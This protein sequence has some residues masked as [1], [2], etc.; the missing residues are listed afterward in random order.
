[1]RSSLISVP[2]RRLRSVCFIACGV[3][4]SIALLPIPS[5]AGETTVWPTLVVPAARQTVHLAIGPPKEHAGEAKP[6]IQGLAE[7]GSS[8]EV[9]P[10]N[11]VPGS[12]ALGTADCLQ[13]AASIPPRG[14]AEGPRRFKIVF[15]NPSRASASEFRFTQ[16]D[17]KSIGLWDGERPVLVYNYGVVTDESVPKTDARGSRGCY[18]HP[19][20]GLDGEVITD[21]FPK[22]HYHHHGIFWSWPHVEIGGREYDLWVYKN[23]EQRFVRWLGRECGSAAAALG[24]EN[25][26]FVGEKKVMIERVWVRVYKPAGI[27]RLHRPGV[28]LDPGRGADHA[29]RSGRQELWRPESALRPTAREGDPDHRPE[30]TN[31]GGPARHAAGLGRLECKVPGRGE[32]QRRSDFRRSGPSRF[33]AHLAHPPLRYPLRR[34]AGRACEDLPAGRAHPLELPNLDPQGNGRAGRLARGV[35]CLWRGPQ[36]TL[37]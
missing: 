24:V 18:I 15:G 21:D 11:L 16:P 3:L 4:I 6:K 5:N 36:S 28:H 31:Q 25:G 37:E 1:M 30:R 9:I 32:P 34:L 12:S 22:D 27:E 33:P 20:Y 7:I 2:A 13:V 8:G 29:P 26:W 35:R 14:D 17:G 23:I 19:V 10:A